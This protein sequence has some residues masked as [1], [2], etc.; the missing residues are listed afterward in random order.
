MDLITWRLKLSDVLSD[1]EVKCPKLVASIKAAGIDGDLPYIRKGI[2]PS[3]IELIKGERSVVS[4]ISTLAVDRDGEVVLP[5]GMDTTHFDLNPI[6]TFGH[7]YN[8]L[9]LGTGWVIPY[10][11]S[12]PV[13]IRAKTIYPTEKANPFSAQVLEYQREGFPLAKSIGFIPLK[14]VTPEDKNWVDA[15]KSWRERR[16]ESFEM[17]GIKAGDRP[18]EPDPNLIWEKWLLLEYSD[19]P[20]PSNPEAVNIAVSKGLL[21]ADRA[22]LYLPQNEN[23]VDIAVRQ[24]L[25]SADSPG[26]TL[27]RPEA[28]DDIE[29]KEGRVISAKTR[30]RLTDTRNATSGA[31]EAI[32]DLLSETATTETETGK[33]LDKANGLWNRTLPKSFNIAEFDEANTVFRYSLF[34]KF[35]ECQVKEIYVNTYDIPSPLI[36]TYL[37]AISVVTADVTVDDT[38]RFSYDGKESPP[39][40]SYIQLNS[41]NQKRFLVNGSEYCHDGD[42]PLIKDFSPGWCGLEFAIVTSASN[43]SKSD[44]I[45]NAIHAEADRNHMMKG[46]KFALSGEFLS[47][48]DDEWS[49][50]I[51]HS[52]DKQAIQKSLEITSKTNGNSRGLLFV[53]PPGTGKTKA[54]RTI[55]NDTDNTFIWV[56]A[57]DFMY[58]MPDYILS[59][60]F[61]MARKLA[62]TVLFMEDVDTSLDKDLLKTELDGLKQNKGLMTILTT[63][64]PDRLPKALID[65]PG[66]FHHV[67]LFALPD[68]SQRK[69]MFK[70]WAGDIEATVLDTLV[71]NTEEF[72]GAHIN[73]LVE[74]S[75]TI[76]EDEQMSISKALLESLLRMSDQIEL[77]AGLSRTETKELFN[78][79]DLRQIGSNVDLVIN[80]PP[81]LAEIAQV[82]RE[83]KAEKQQSK[84]EVALESLIEDFRFESGDYV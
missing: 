37:E 3:G 12:A 42:M 28:T 14:S 52:K 46:E 45:M 75:K 20:I 70:L 53:G 73:H 16:I 18:D 22:S 43:E 36:G 24:G 61:D 9:P 1:I 55:M 60:A 48:T 71:E 50:L 84:A 63:N 25:I 15:V 69:D 66:R 65:R 27:M 44:E 31:T 35:L 77:V 32:D 40:R 82:R 51:I 83:M 79:E 11:K 21:S 49:E 38:R 72:S 78:E 30:K 41:E 80:A 62:P 67:L 57:R 19:V 39:T 59:L 8:S 54:G 6:V 47:G 34:T 5:E 23:A 10:P 7:D 33:V 4:T 64:H 26:T 74:Y 2:V 13:E 56:S 58:G 17:K 29:Q 68:A 81:T 76:A